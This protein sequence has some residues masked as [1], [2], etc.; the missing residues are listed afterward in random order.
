MR[1]PLCSRSSSV[2]PIFCP[3]KSKCVSLELMAC[4]P[5]PPS[6]CPQVRG[7]CLLL[8]P[9]SICPSGSSS[10]VPSPSGYYRPPHPAFKTRWNGTC[11]RNAL[12]P[13]LPHPAH[14]L[15]LHAIME[16]CPGTWNCVWYNSHL[17]GLIAFPPSPLGPGQCLV[18]MSYI[19]CKYFMNE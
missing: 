1:P 18:R 12:S 13:L 15:P 6:L 19:L 9:F 8:A 7:F 5:S 14:T 16:S 3:M 10:F 4:G 2:T 17:P 11:P